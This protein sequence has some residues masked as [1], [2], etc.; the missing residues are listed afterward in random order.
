MVGL[1]ALF[2][3]IGVW[4]YQFRAASLYCTFVACLCQLSVLIFTAIAIFGKYS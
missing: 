3:F 1:N 2:M 4:K